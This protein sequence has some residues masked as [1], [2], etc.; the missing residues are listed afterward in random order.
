MKSREIICKT[1]EKLEIL[2]KNI[3]IP[4]RK[5]VFTEN[6]TDRGRKEYKPCYNL[7]AKNKKKARKTKILCKMTEIKN[8]DAKVWLFAHKKAPAGGGRF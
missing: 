1:G 3:K 4:R 6:G 5:P 7:K 8:A 2:I